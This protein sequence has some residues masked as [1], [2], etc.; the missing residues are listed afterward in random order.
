MI[1]ALVAGLE[2]ALIF[3]FIALWRQ[4]QGSKIGFWIAIVLGRH[5]GGGLRAHPC[6]YHRLINRI[7]PDVVT[8]C[9]NFKL[10]H[11]PILP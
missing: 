1:P 5:R 11:S 4:R 6:P 3:V 7:T 2:L 9:S 8:I 10:T